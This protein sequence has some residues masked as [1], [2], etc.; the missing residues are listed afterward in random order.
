VSRHRLVPRLRS[1]ERGAPGP[2]VWGLRSRAGSARRPRGNSLIRTRTAPL[3]GRSISRVVGERE[4][5]IGGSHLTVAHHRAL[6]MLCIPRMRS[7]AG[8]R[9]ASTASSRD[10]GC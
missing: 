10:S 3:R 6:D 8:S 2:R 7:A 5:I 1:D 4:Y 9:S